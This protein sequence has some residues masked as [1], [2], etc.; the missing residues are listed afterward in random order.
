MKIETGY[1]LFLGAAT[2][3]LDAKTAFG[4]AQ[5]RPEHCIGQ[6]RLPGGA[7]D[8]GLPEMTPAQAAAAGARTLVIGVAP[9]GGR[10]EPAWIASLV[11]ALEAGLDIASGMHAR[12]AH[13][14]VLVETA[15]RC[16]RQLHDVREPGPNL[17]VA[18]GAKRPGLRLLTV[19]T[20][21]AVGK[22][23]A[24]LSIHKAMRERGL[25]ATFRATGQ[26]GILISGGGVPIDAV[27]S[28]FVAG[29]AE[30]LSPA[31]ELDHWD[32]IE[33][34]GALT[35]PAYAGVSLGLL[36]GSQ[37]DAIVVC[38][39]PA[40]AHVDGYPDYPLP[41]LER[42]IELNVML[43]RLTNPAARCVGV[44][45]N[46]SRLDADARVRVAAEIEGRL[47]LTCFDPIADGAGRLVSALLGDVDAAA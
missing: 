47:G 5:W 22:K 29:A 4:I 3:A 30:Q 35:H 36:H 11:E 44:A 43:A 15:A 9:F 31:A 16:G 20:D 23:Y 14:P 37:P 25:K 26:T 42:C 24:A 39:D 21:C 7:V 13:V 46:G 1:L 6:W 28:D 32:V 19:G 12:L 8:V 33:G 45:I 17:T 40:R 2:A 41:S 10:L 38:H 27:V 18:T 34:Q